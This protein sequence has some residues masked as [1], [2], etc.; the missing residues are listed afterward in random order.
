MSKKKKGFRKG[1]G[2]GL[3]CIESKSNGQLKGKD[4]G[5]RLRNPNKGGKL[6]KEN[7]LKGGK[8]KISR[9]KKH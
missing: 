1:G 6:I 5:K 9:N 2:L 7:C 3:G 4:R 8:P